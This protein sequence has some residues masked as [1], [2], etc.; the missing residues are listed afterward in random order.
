M[1]IRGKD[2]IWKLRILFTCSMNAQNL[3][4][5]SNIHWSNGKLGWMWYYPLAAWMLRIYF[6]FPTFTD[7]MENW[8]ECGIT[9]LRAEF[10]KFTPFLKKNGKSPLEI[11]F[12][13]LGSIP[14][15]GRILRIYLSFLEFTKKICFYKI[16]KFR[17]FFFF[18]FN[19]E[20]RKKQ[21]L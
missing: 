5:F 1:E 4:L 12:S 21:F 11:G 6:F 9:H 2:S 13:N 14:P 19:K 3:L 20:N 8:G 10:S 17:H 7:Q 16:C 15:E 18:I